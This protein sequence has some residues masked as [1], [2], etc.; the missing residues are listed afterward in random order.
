[1]VVFN[2]AVLSP[3]AVEISAAIALF[4]LVIRL[5]RGL[6]WPNWV[7]AATAVSGW[8]LA[9]ARPLGPFVVAAAG[10]LLVVLT[11]P[12]LVRT[13]WR[14]RPRPILAMG[15]VIGSGCAVNLAWQLFFV[16]ILPA[17]PSSAANL[18]PA[19]AGFMPEV[20]GETIGVFGY[21]DTLMPR[22]AYA[23]GGL[24]FVLLLGA[25]L[26]GR[27][28]VAVRRLEVLLLVE[29]VA[30]L[31]ISAFVVLPLGVDPQGRYVLPLLVAIPLLAG[32]MVATWGRFSRTVG[33]SIAV[34][35]GALQAVAWYSAAHRFA[36]GLDGPW[37]FISRPEWQPPAGWAPWLLTA[38]LACAGLAFAGLRQARE[39]VTGNTRP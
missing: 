36:V 39:G 16:R 35:V 38:V 33:Q 23:L 11:G 13:A 20:L 1:M 7:L 17:P 5:G 22:P 19:A 8:L 10:L 31:A 25:A 24:L 30:V 14:A 12:A 27:P 29:V 34:G 9:V 6:P 37:W 4:A 21:L 28:T 2:A 3:S 18:L 32:D 26:L 15:L